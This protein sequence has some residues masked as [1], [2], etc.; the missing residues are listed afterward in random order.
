MAEVA[1][2]QLEYLFNRNYLVK[3]GS[4]SY[5][6]TYRLDTKVD[7]EGQILHLQNRLAEQEESVQKLRKEVEF[8]KKQ[9]EYS[10]RKAAS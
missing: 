8:F 7:D 9:A 6:S 1:I 2:S 4:A 5:P 10:Y 3:A